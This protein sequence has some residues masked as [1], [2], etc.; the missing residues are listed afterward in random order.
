[1][2]AELD[3]LLG[4]VLHRGRMSTLALSKAP[5]RLDRGRAIS[6]G[7]CRSKEPGQGLLA[8]IAQTTNQERFE[9]YASNSPEMPP[10]DGGAMNTAALASRHKLASRV[11]RNEVLVSEIN[12]H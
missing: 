6:P 3:T 11:E 1:M 8:G 12:G 5:R 9:F 2:P 10:P 4:Q 7:R